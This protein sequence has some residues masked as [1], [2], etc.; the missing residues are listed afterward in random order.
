[1][2]RLAAGRDGTALA[3]TLPSVEEL[4]DRLREEHEGCFTE[5][6]A[7]ESG[8]HIRVLLVDVLVEILAADDERRGFTYDE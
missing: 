3:A 2:D 6:Q 8:A 5:A 4:A 1:M 7:L